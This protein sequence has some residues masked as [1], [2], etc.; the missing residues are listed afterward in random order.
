MTEARIFLSRSEFAERIGDKMD[1]LARY[2]LPD[3]DAI[4]GAAENEPPQ[5]GYP[6]PWTRGTPHAQAKAGG[7][8][9][10]QA[11]SETPHKHVFPTEN[12]VRGHTLS[13]TL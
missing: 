11:P 10:T 2:K 8:P 12:P 6:K 13:V 1:T 4:I 3:P 7:H 9:K 5:D